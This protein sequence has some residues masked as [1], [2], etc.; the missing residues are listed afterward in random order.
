MTDWHAV[1]AR[2]RADMRPRAGDGYVLLAMCHNLL[3]YEYTRE[4][5]AR[6]VFCGWAEIRKAGRRWEYAITPTG[7]HAL[8]IADDATA[9]GAWGVECMDR[10][11]E[12]GE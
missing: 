12:G 6:M 3:A 5:L 2:I 7:R 8:A 10:M 11:I 4:P 9:L 1:A